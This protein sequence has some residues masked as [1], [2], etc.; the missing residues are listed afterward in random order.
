MK[1]GT[2]WGHFSSNKIDIW[3]PIIQDIS[4]PK[5]KVSLVDIC[6]VK[7]EGKTPPR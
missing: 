7:Y 2:T 3:H 5:L 4:R 1:L 6:H